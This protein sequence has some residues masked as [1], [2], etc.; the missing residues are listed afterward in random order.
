MSRNRE[1]R[2]ERER[3]TAGQWNSQNTHDIYWSHLLPYMDVVYGVLK[4]LQLLLYVTTSKV[5]DYHNKYND[6]EKAWTIV[7]ITTMWYRDEQCC[8]KN[9]DYICL[10]QDCHKF[11]FV[12]NAIYAK[13]NKAKQ[14][15]NK[16]SYSC[17]T[18]FLSIHHFK[19]T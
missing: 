12:R 19:V 18:F 16:M 13:C 15:L 1:A 5:T 6:N 14:Y 9:G 7:R 17:T 8:W 11:Q 2:G 10:M 4:Q 3:G